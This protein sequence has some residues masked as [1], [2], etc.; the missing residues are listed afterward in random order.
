[1]LQGK[2]KKLLEYLINYYDLSLIDKA[3]FMAIA[4]DIISHPE[5]QKRMDNEKY[6]HHN[7][8]SLGEHIISDAI[9]TYKL[10]QKKNYNEQEQKRA[11]KIALFHDLYEFPWQNSTIIKNCT[12]N[13]HRFT[14]PIEGAINAATWYPELFKEKESAEIIIDGIIHHMFPFPVRVLNKKDAQLNNQ[15][16]FEQLDPRIKDLIITSS[17]RCQI[18]NISLCPSKFKEGRIISKADKIVSQEEDLTSWN[19]LIASVTRKN[20]KLQK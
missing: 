7:T 10:T 18:G 16:K 9:V 12:T 2:N 8:T 4:E 20:K 3:Y 15:Q 17:M 1:M 6:P 19:G 5:F 13:K 11:V 14:H